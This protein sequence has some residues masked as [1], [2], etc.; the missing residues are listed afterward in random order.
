MNILIEHDIIVAQLEK[1]QCHVKITHER[2]RGEIETM[3]EYDFGPKPDN[4]H[5][6]S[7]LEPVAPISVRSLAWRQRYVS[8]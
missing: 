4:S 3:L 8:L 5:S 7:I 1:L 6:P 2:A